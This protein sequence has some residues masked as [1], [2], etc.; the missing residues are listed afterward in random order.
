MR[1]LRVFDAVARHAGF[2]RAAAELHL[3]QPTVSMQVKQLSETVG[4][5][6]FEQIGKR[7]FPTDAGR[8]L[9]DYIAKHTLGFDQLEAEVNKYA[10]ACTHNRPT[11]TVVMQKGFFEIYK[12]QQGEY[13]GSVLT[14][15]RISPLPS[16]KQALLLG[17]RP[18]RVKRP[19]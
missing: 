16:A 10:L 11:D 3:S 8:L 13:M 9:R 6:L 1:Q 2:S 14:G 15:I 17:G 4:L 18:I 7:I 12:Q 5:P 19:S